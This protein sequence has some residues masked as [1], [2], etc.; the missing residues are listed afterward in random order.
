MKISY[1]NAFSARYSF[2]DSDN[3]STIDQRYR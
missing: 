2:T 3:V 1:W